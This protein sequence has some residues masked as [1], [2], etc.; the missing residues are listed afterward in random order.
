MIDTFLLLTLLHFACVK[1]HAEP[2]VHSQY[3]IKYPAK[4]HP[5]GSCPSHEDMVNLTNEFHHN[6]SELLMMTHSC[7]GTPGWRRVAYLDMTDP[8][9]SCPP[10]LNL[11]TNSTRVRACGRA[12]DLGGGC[13]SIFMWQELQSTAECVGG[14]GGI[15]TAIIMDSMVQ[16]MVFW[17]F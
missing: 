10:G 6:I 14:S 2:Q 8:S 15:S 5:R 13:S 16:H 17:S 7:G 12:I 11:T 3:P 4:I 9:Q 1:G